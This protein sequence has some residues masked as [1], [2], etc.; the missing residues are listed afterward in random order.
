MGRLELSE[1]GEIVAST[2]GAGRGGDITITARDDVSITGTDFATNTPATGLISRAVAGS[3]D[4]GS[5]TLNVGSLN[6]SRGGQIATN[7]YTSGRGGD[8]TITARDAMTMTGSF[9]IFS[10]QAQP[11]STGDAGDITLDVGSLELTGGSQILSGT[12]GVGRGGNIS[13]TARDAVTIS[14]TNPAGSFVSGLFATGSTGNAG[15]ITLDVGSL[16]LSEGGRI[17]ASTLGVGRGGNLNITVRDAVTISG[18]N[19][20][21]SFGSGL[22]ANTTSTGDSGSITL[23][24]GR[25]DISSGGL[26]AATTSGAGRGGDINVSIRD[27]IAINGM[28]PTG[29]Y[30][31]GLYASTFPGSTGDA[32]DIT[33][34]T[35][36][37]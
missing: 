5:I 35:G 23:D 8:I 28:N 21:G 26:I 12:L 31:S 16:D 18:T 22:F 10:Q 25:L 27:A 20:A 7:T 9:Y 34:D 17:N 33:V 37:F 13:V 19:P 11:G 6:L 15:S 36:H 30:A 4:A 14:G 2:R 3:G 32:G 29:V 24:A 1:G